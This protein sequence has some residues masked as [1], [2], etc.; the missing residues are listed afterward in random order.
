MTVAGL[1]LYQGKSMLLD[2]QRSGLPS[3]AWLRA[4]GDAEVVQLEPMASPSAR[5]MFFVFGKKVGATNLLFQDRAGRCA[6]VEV[7][8]GVDAATVEAALRRLLPNEA[9]IKVSA[10]ALSRVLVT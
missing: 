2:L 5:A 7:A 8:V 1:G 6:M 3:P 9:G 4:V 10:A